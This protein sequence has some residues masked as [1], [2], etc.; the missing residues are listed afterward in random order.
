MSVILI[1]CDPE[2]FVKNKKGVH[3]SAHGMVPGTKR[4]PYQ[5]SAGAIQVDGMALEFNIKPAS[6][7]DEFILACGAML[8][9]LKEGLPKEHTLDIVPA[10]EFSQ[11]EF[12]RAPEESK[13]LGCDPDFN[14]WTGQIN[15]RPNGDTL[16]RTAAG[17]IHIGWTKDKD[18]FEDSHFRDCCSLVKQLDYFLGLPSLHWD[19]DD[20]RRMLYGKAGAFR[21]KP[22]GVEYRVLSNQWLLSKERMSFVYT[23]AYRAT[24]LLL[25]GM[26]M[27]REYGALAISLFEDTGKANN[28]LGSRQ[29]SKL[30]QNIGLEIPPPM[31]PSVL[32]TS[33]IKEKG[34][35]T[36]GTAFK[37]TTGS[38]GNP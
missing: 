5:V 29:G 31:L 25:E 32:P 18:P 1:G 23:S 7:R 9:V 22:Y 6:S 34:T 24:T 4:N 13:E 10:V 3:V 19:R 2:V 11:P 15:P 16:L 38:W 27:E 30:L 37:Y 12:D 20:R 26:S 21:P 14:A 35:I 28:F 36:G 33:K 17:H 8:E